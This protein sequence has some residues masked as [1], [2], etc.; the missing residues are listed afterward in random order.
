MIKIK[1]LLKKDSS[2][3]PAENLD[4]VDHVNVSV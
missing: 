1:W 3:L 2:T 4:F